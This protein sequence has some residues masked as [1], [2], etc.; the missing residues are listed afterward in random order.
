MFGE[1]HMRFFYDLLLQELGIFD[2]NLEVKHSDDS[3][4]NIHYFATHYITQGPEGGVMIDALRKTNFTTNSL[5]LISFGSWHLH[6]MGLAK[7]ILDLREVL[8]PE[9]QRI[10]DI[11]GARVVV[12]TGP[13]KFKQVG[14]F[15]GIENTASMTAI[16]EAVSMLMPKDVIVLDMVNPTRGFLESALPA[17]D[18]DCQNDNQCQCHMLCRLGGGSNVTGRFGTELFHLAMNEACAKTDP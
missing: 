5:V 14:A 10:L 4:R 17:I 1:S 6:G 2:G 11:Y 7:T 12:F 13:A 16:L 3:T 9:V 8:V 18:W 15:A